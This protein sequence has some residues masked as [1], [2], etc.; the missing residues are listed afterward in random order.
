MS[1]LL[2][3][4]AEPAEP[5]AGLRLQ[6]RCRQSL[7]PARSC[8]PQLKE[9]DGRWWPAFAVDQMKPAETAE[10]IAFYAGWRLRLLSLPPYL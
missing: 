5:A 10:L 1:G 2:T 4:R 9:Y 6:R 3:G 8:Q 7:R